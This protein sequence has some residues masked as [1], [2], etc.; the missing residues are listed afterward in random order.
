M[1]SKQ[2]YVFIAL[3]LTAHFAVAQGAD[4]TKPFSMTSGSSAKAMSTKGPLVLESIIHGNKIHTAVINGQVMQVGD[5]IGEHRLVA[6]NND[7]AVLR[8]LTERVKL[9]VFSGV[10]VK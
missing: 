4:P 6:V 8:T 7:S 9:S 5:V 10:I 3:I 1:V 2:T